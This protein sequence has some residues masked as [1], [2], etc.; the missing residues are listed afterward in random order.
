MN[1]H[2]RAI[3]T[4]LRIGSWSASKFDKRIS[5]ETNKAHGAA[6]DAGR[7]N[8][9]LMPSDATSYKALQTH[10]GA[11]RT[12]HY[13]QTLPWSDDGWR[14]LPIANHTAYT[15]A[16]RAGQHTFDAL[17]S[18]FVS[19]YPSLQQT[20]KIMLNGMYKDED[21]PDD[22]GS[23][24]SMG[25]EFS[26]V[27]S[28]GD[29]RVSLSDE[30]I[31]IISAS[32]TNRVEQAFKAAQEDA[33]KRLFDAV[34]KMHEKL[35]SPEAIFRDSLVTNAR[36]LCDILTRL[37]LSDDAKLEELRKETEALASV[38]PQ[39]LREKPETRVE[40]AKQAQSILDAMT[41]AY[42]SQLFS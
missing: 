30:E 36:E 15:D 4:S 25:V 32:T 3:L 19:D 34:Q 37:N 7:F 20:A 28:A 23:K 40:T 5:E 2:T 10:L 39:Q 26:P 35:A 29:Y 13:R 1:M 8:K 31:A 21:Y 24:Y 14:L 41:G 9:R 12:E 11:M 27:P 22:I 18:A 33:V 6:S 42:G 17:L 16:M 38:E